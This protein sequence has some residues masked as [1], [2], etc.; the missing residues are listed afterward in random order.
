MPIT[1]EE[2]V[3]LNPKEKA[4]KAIIKDFGETFDCREAGYILEDGTMLD[5]SGKKEGGTAKT[6]SYDHREISRAL[7]TG[8]K[9]VDGTDAMFF[10]QKQANALTFSCHGSWK[11]GHGIFVQLD[12]L[13]TPTEKQLNRVVQCCK[14]FEAEGVYYDIYT[15]NVTRDFSGEIE[16][17]NCVKAVQK[18]K[19]DFEK[20]KKHEKK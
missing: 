5:L 9:G 19:A 15:K 10:F 3:K 16:K 12:T 6:R 11:E 7:K 17:P 1:D 8:R 13:Q 2:L 18:M 14:L 20:A 4:V